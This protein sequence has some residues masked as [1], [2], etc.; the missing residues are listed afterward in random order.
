MPAVSDNLNATPPRKLRAAVIGSGKIS[1][2][3]LRFLGGSPN[4]ALAGVCDLSPSLARYG[5]TR[6]KAEQA[7]TDHAKMLADVKPDVVHV[8]TPPHTHVKLVGDCLTGGAHVVVEKPIAPTH[9]EFRKLWDLAQRHDRKL[10]ED[11]NYRF[12]EPVLA[13][14]DLVDRDELGEVREVEVR[15]VLNIL[16]PGS[17]TLD[18]ALP[19]P[20]HSLPAGILHDFITHLCYLT[21]RFMP[22]VDESGGP[23]VAAAWSKHGTDTVVKFD[24]LD[25][26]VIS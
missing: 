19:N 23:R 1:E 2:E 14:E 4:V 22:D 26:T 15:M 9:G 11:H 10:V 12:N 5:A 6:F 18:T 24:D 17:R 20:A 21:L 8:L 16:E 3:H 7:F 13:I 25:A